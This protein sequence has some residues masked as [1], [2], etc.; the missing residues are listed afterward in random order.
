[1]NHHRMTQMLGPPLACL[2]NGKKGHMCPELQ[3]QE[4]ILLPK[5]LVIPYT[6][7]SASRALSLSDALNHVSLHDE[8]DDWGPANL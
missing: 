8:K 7:N 3:M 6:W 1:M 4:N 2:S 5:S